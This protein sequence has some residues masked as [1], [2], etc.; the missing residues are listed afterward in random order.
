MQFAL[1]AFSSAVTSSS[2][3][4][5]YAITLSLPAT[6]YSGAA[7]PASYGNLTDCLVS[8]DGF[9]RQITTST[10]DTTTLISGYPSAQPQLVFAGPL[11]QGDGVL[12]NLAQTIY[13]LFNPYDPTSP[14]YRQARTGL[15]IV[16]QLGLYDGSPTPDLV[17]VFTGTVDQVECDV[18]GSVTM[19]CLDRSNTISDQA[20]LP[21]VI[22]NAP[23]NAGLTNEYAIDYL[24]RHASPKQYYSWPSQRPNCLIA[25]GMRSSVWPEVGSLYIAGSPNPPGFVPS[26]APGVFGNALLGVTSGVTGAAYLMPSP[27]PSGSAV[28]FE[29][30]GSGEVGVE[31]SDDASSWIYLL[32]LNDGLGSTK[33]VFNV[34]SASG[35]SANVVFTVDLTTSHY[36]GILIK[37]SVGSNAV[38]GTF[39]YDNTSTPFSVTALNTRPVVTQTFATVFGFG[40]SLVEAFQLT[41]ET[42]PIPNNTFTPT[43]IL[44]PGGS[45]NPLTAL[46][47]VTGQTTWQVLQD[48]AASEAAVIGFNELGQAFFTNRETIQ[49]AV[50]ARTVTSN[51]SLMTLATLEQQSLVATHVQIPVDQLAIQPAG[52]VW[53]A[54]SVLQINPGTPLIFTATLSDPAVAVKTSDSGYYP[55]TGAV[56]GNTYWQACTTADGTGS[57]V[58]FGIAV[59][60]VQTSSSQLQVTITNT[61]GQVLFLVTPAGYPSPI[62]GTTGSPSLILGGQAIIGSSAGGSVIADIQWPPI[63]SGGATTNS[64]FGEVL[65]QISANDWVQDLPSAQALALY[66]IEDLS[67]PKPMVRNISMMPDARLQNLDRITLIDTDISGINADVLVIGINMSLSN[68]TFSQALDARFWSRPGSWILGVQGSSELSLTTW[69]Y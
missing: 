55:N 38:T 7:I 59:T 64:Q 54:S 10:P 67:W 53:A 63:G 3:Q 22:T 15:Q 2:Q 31:V 69:I 28:F 12:P 60:V 8:M 43:L 33:A 32:D 14:L 47:D 5:A 25:A 48:I 61:S 34:Q 17:T 26:F 23:Y 6:T 29:F 36:Y 44:D 9:Y 42:S 11:S 18:D 49:T 1:A 21:P 45:L 37:C 16:I 19:T 39:Y 58:I 46:P 13:W 62:G 40:G 41:T 27:I 65:L 68:G 66:Y 20:T 57:P 35:L 4:I 56:V 30:W 50:V 51:V 52:T 24:L